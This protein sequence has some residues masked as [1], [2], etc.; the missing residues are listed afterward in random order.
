VCVIPGGTHLLAPPQDPAEL[1]A[2]D[3]EAMG[4]LVDTLCV[5]YPVTIMDCAPLSRS[6]ATRAAG[7]HEPVSS[8]MPVA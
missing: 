3:V 5:L 2:I 7:V 8:A 4:E 6:E 1:R